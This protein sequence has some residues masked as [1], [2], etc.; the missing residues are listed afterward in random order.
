MT[1]GEINASLQ[2]GQDPETLSIQDAVNLIEAR[3]AK[4]ASGDVKPKRGRGGKKKAAPKAKANAAETES[5][6]EAPAAKPKRAPRKKKAA[7]AEE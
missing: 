5:T 1:D 3:A 4:I 6:E 7:S 2:R